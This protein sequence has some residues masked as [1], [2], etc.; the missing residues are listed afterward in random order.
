MWLHPTRSQ[1]SL[2]KS[3]SPCPS[4]GK[5]A[6][7]RSFYVN[8]T[9]NMHL[10]LQLNVS[11]FIMN[12]I[13]LDL[14]PSVVPG[15]GSC[16]RQAGQNRGPHGRDGEGVSEV[17]VPRSAAPADAGDPVNRPPSES[18]DDV[19]NLATPSAAAAAAASPAVS[20][21]AESGAADG[22]TSASVEQEEFTVMLPLRQ[23]VKTKEFWYD[24]ALEV[25][26]MALTVYIV[27]WA[28]G[29]MGC[30]FKKWPLCL[31]VQDRRM[32]IPHDEE[33]RYEEEYYDDEDDDLEEEED[34][35]H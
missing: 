33:G 9:L 10:I 12:N 7:F 28:Y 25:V 32:R 29:K 34:D 4:Q 27:F 18:S 8:I 2:Q 3:G 24:R 16:R 21:D 30:P 17:D 13:C 1:S 22:Q 26:V 5:A 15:R 35:L 6:Y 19:I 23:A 11:L 31:L 20:P 14:Y